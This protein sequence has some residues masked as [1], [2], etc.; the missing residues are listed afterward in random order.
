MAFLDALLRLFVPA[1]KP[2]NGD[3]PGVKIERRATASPNFVPGAS[4]S[5]TG[6]IAV[7]IADL[8]GEG[9]NIVADRLADLLAKTEGL[10]VVRRHEPLCL[11]GPGGPVDKLSLAAEQGRGWLHDLPADLL[12]W[13]ELSA[14]NNMLCYR[15]LPAYAEPDGTV[16]AFGLGDVLDLPVSPGTVAERV[17]VATTLAAAIRARVGPKAPAIEALRA[18]LTD[19]PDLAAGPF[20]NLAP[21]PG[22][23][24]LLGLGHAYAADLRNGGAEDR[25]EKALACYRAAA[26]RV[27]ALTEPMLWSVIENHL[28]AALTALAERDENP[29]RLAE[30]AGAY[31][32]IA[33]ALTRAEFPI[34]WALAQVRLGGTLFRQ[35]KMAGK[36]QSYREAA[37]AYEQALTVFTSAQHPLRWADLMN[38]YGVLLTALGE[39]LSGTAALEQAVMVFRKSLDVRRRE[40]MPLLWAQ[41]ASNLGAA[42]FA[43][44]K[45]NGDGATLREAAACFEGA[46]DIYAQNGQRKAVLLLQKNLQRVQRL[47]DTRGEKLAADVAPKGAQPLMAPKGM[48]VPAPAKAPAKK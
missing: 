12:V 6:G 44:A 27:T 32:A 19:M 28:A 20:A 37:A 29:E 40:T 48:A 16:G 23:S 2:A 11:A 25:L 21:G 42:A 13:G 38:H 9:G 10:D 39:H 33:E 15:F 5:G 24:V 30:A 46:V 4:G 3:K 41:T 47:I 34:D 17:I 35:G 1:A 31:R 18:L 36:P 14:E 7:V 45:R 43:L 26:G 22:A 8:D